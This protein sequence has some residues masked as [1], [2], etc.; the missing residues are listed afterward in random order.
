MKVCHRASLLVGH[1]WVVLSVAVGLVV[2]YILAVKKLE[3]EIQQGNEVQQEK[4][5]QHEKEE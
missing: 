1:P 5:T 4:D 2:L 3:R